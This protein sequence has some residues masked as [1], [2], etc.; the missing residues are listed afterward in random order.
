MF[1]V[2][3][4]ISFMQ[5]INDLIS[6]TKWFFYRRDANIKKALDFCR[7]LNVRVEVKDSPSSGEILLLDEFAGGGCPP[8]LFQ[9]GKWHFRPPQA[10]IFTS[11]IGFTKE[12]VVHVICHEL[13]HYVDYFSLQTPTERAFFRDGCRKLNWAEF[14][15]I[16]D[17][18]EIIRAEMTAWAYAL[19]MEKE[20]YGEALRGFNEHF[21]HAVGSYIEFIE[22]R[23]KAY[24]NKLKKAEK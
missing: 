11:A 5:M 12:D 18:K 24:L 4:V 17:T 20:L 21:E 19:D 22:A 15:P 6:V 3:L 2:V 23:N 16:S 7:K 1:L 10:T 9:N 14:F 13:G 8:I